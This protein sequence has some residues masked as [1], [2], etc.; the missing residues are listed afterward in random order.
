MSWGWWE[1]KIS[2]GISTISFYYSD[3]CP[4]SFILL[5][6]IHSKWNHIFGR[7]GTS[8]SIPAIH[9]TNR[10]FTNLFTRGSKN[11]TAFFIKDFSSEIK[12]V[13]VVTLVTN[14]LTT[15]IRSE[16]YSSS[17]PSLSSY[18]KTKTSSIP[19]F[20]PLPPTGRWTC[21][22]SPAKNTLPILIL[23]TWR[24]FILKE[25]FHKHSDSL[26]EEGRYS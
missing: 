12:F 8:W 9:S 5:S 10:F 16:L 3:Y 26:R 1:W 22:A 7:F 11:V 6:L 14:S 15:G 21:A 18:E 2:P 17:L 20:I 4:I 19:K 25:L 24:L 13:I 23:S